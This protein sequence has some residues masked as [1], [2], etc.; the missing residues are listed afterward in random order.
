MIAPTTRCA[1]TKQTDMTV[2]VQQRDLKDQGKNAQ[3]TQKGT[4]LHLQQ[5]LSHLRRKAR[6]KRKIG[7]TGS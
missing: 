7:Q 5:A 3:V 1:L 6:L 4:A 2:N